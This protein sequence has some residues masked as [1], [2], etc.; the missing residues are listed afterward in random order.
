VTD[1]SVALA[2]WA[3][4]FTPA[5]RLQLRRGA[6]LHDIG[7]MGIPDAILHKPGPLDD[8][9]WAIMR[10]HPHLAYDM[11]H[12]IDYL[13]PALDIPLAH[14]EWWNGSGYPLGL[15]GEAI[16]RAARLFAIVD[17]WDALRSDRP[18]RAAWPADKVRAYLAERSGTQFDP[19]L[20]AAFLEMPA[21]RSA[22]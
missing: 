9:E 12:T 20:L 5:E 17:V 3:G 21:A 13:R 16:P 7:K 2:E 19:Q 6:L 10:Q 4:G 14:H 8:A 15:A 1:L 22:A 18:Y 11:L